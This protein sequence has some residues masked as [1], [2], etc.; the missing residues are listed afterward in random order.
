MNAVGT[1]YLQSNGV[2]TTRYFDGTKVYAESIVT[3]KGTINCDEISKQSDVDTISSTLAEHTQALSQIE[4]KVNINTQSISDIIIN[5]NKLLF[6]ITEST[7]VYDWDESST[8]LIPIQQQYFPYNTEIGVNSKTR[9][10]GYLKITDSYDTFRGMKKFSVQ[11][12]FSDFEDTTMGYTHTLE[13]FYIPDVVINLR[14]KK[15]Y[16]LKSIETPAPVKTFSLSKFSMGIRII[17]PRGTYTAA[18]DILKNVFTDERA[19]NVVILIFLGT[20][21]NSNS[22]VTSSVSF[23]RFSCIFMNSNC[24]LFLGGAGL[25]ATDL[26]L[27]PPAGCNQNLSRYSGR[28]DGNIIATNLYKISIALKGASCSGTIPSSYATTVFDITPAN[29]STFGRGLEMFLYL[30]FV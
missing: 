14:T 4:D 11:V 10:Y 7:Y 13:R 30:P 26:Y 18:N 2:L 1:K 6:P 3:P 9:T 21:T 29:A 8:D 25:G 16:T 24:T 27:M 12:D 19:L 15:V 17:F 28:T 22:N 20:Y 5:S 23:T